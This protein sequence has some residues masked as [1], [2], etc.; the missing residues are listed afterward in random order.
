MARTAFDAC[1]RQAFLYGT[2]SLFKGRAFIDHQDFGAAAQLSQLVSHEDAAGSCSGNYYI[3]PFHYATSVKEDPVF[4][5][6]L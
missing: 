4:W 6:L 3:I 2:L 1:R 5:A